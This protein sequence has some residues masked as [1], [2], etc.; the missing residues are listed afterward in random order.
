MLVFL[1]FTTSAIVFSPHL[2]VQKVALLCQ[3]D[4]ANATF[5]GVHR[6]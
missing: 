2:V 1:K 5:F 3:Q 4:S 6:V